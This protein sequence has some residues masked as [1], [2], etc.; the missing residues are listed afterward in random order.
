[1]FKE[2]KVDGSRAEGVQ[3][4][5]MHDRPS[6]EST[7]TQD[8]DR[9]LSDDVSEAPSTGLPP[10]DGGRGAW[11]CLLGCWLVEAIIWGFAI[12]FG[13]FQRY[14]SSH[15]LF[16]HSNSIATIGSLAM[17][18]SYLGM[19]L[20]ISVALKFPHYRRKVCAVG[21][22]LCLVGLA[23]ASLAT[24]LWQLLLSQGLF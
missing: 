21:W 20:A 7:N 9:L 14:Y 5:Q 10:V 17:G 11:M 2:H 16:K 18:V 13:V 15:P 22:L 23:A 24:S 8:F 3:L 6:E 1:M 12:S 19:P 4:R